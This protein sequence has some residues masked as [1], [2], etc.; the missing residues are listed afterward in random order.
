MNLDLEYGEDIN[1]NSALDPNKN[2]GQARPPNDN[3]DGKLDPGFLS[4]FTVYTHEP[5]NLGTTNRYL[6]SDMSGFT[7]FLATNNP[8]VL[9]AIAPKLRTMGTVRS[10]LEFALKSGITEQQFVQ[11]E[12]FL[13][14][15]SNAIGLINVNT[16]SAA[17]MG[18]LPG[19]G[20][21]GTLGGGSMN[22]QTIV[23]YRQS[24][25]SRLN[26]IYWLIDALSGIG[27]A[28]VT[29]LVTTVGP[30]VTS[31][32]WQYSADIAAVGRYG[33]GYRRVKFVYDCSSGLPQIVYRQDLTYLGWAL[34]RRLHD[35][36][37]AGT[38]R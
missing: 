12:P 31:R 11:I 9:T 21:D 29:N 2:D 32:S 8:S 14:S 23:S 13:M 36:L 28:N 4:F 15:S 34:G 16:A 35:Q 22:A 7:N 25:Q 38:L 24:N 6:V 19:I 27:S 37:I 3:G 17:V 20:T 18:T 33:R 1:L 5:T 10:V 30:W 26:S